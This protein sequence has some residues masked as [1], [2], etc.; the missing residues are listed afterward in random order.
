MSNRSSFP[1]TADGL[2][3]KIDT[4][5]F[6]KDTVLG[7]KTR[8]AADLVLKLGDPNQETDV[9]IDNLD[10]LRNSVLTG[11]DDLVLAGYAEACVSVLLKHLDTLGMC[12]TSLEE[13]VTSKLLLEVSSVGKLFSAESDQK[14]KLAQHK[15]QI[16]LRIEVHWL[17]ENEAKQEQYKASMLTHLK[18]IS[19]HG[20]N[21]V[22]TEFL[23]N[24]LSEC[25]IDRQPELLS[26]LYDKL[27]QEQP[28]QPAM[29]F[30]QAGLSANFGSVIPGAH[31]AMASPLVLAKPASNKSNV[32]SRSFSSRPSSSDTLSTRQI[33]IGAGKTEKNLKVVTSPS[34]D[35]SCTRRDS[36][37][38][39]EPATKGS[40]MLFPHLMNKKRK[41]KDRL[42]GVNSELVE[43]I[44]LPAHSMTDS[45]HSVDARS[46]RIPPEPNI[47]SG[48]SSEPQADHSSP[49][50]MPDHS[51]LG[52][53][54]VSS[55][56]E[57]G[58]KS[59][60]RTEQESERMQDRI[61][62]LLRKTTLERLKDVDE[63]VTVVGK[64]KKTKSDQLKDIKLAVWEKHYQKLSGSLVKNTALKTPG[65]REFFSLIDT[66]LSAGTKSNSFNLEDDYNFDESDS[67]ALKLLKM[68]ENESL[69]CA[70]ANLVS[71]DGKVVSLPLPVLSLAWPNLG[72][73]VSEV[74]H[75]SS[76]I[77]ICLPCQGQT[78][79][80]FKEMIFNGRTSDLTLT[81]ECLLLDFLGKVGL[82][83]TTVRHSRGEDQ[84]EE[85]VVIGEIYDSE[86]EEEDSKSNEGLGLVA[87][88]WKPR[89]VQPQLASRKLCSPM[90]F[91]DCHQVVKTWNENDVKMAKDTFGGSSAC[92]TKSKMLIHLQHQ[93]KIGAETVSFVLLGHSFCVGFLN[94]LTGCS[95]YL[96]KTV[97]KDY[98]RGV[99][100][101]ENG[102]SGII[103]NISLATMGFIAWFKNFLSIYGQN[104][105]DS[106]VLFKKNYFCIM[107]SLV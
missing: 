92:S 27:N 65:R 106:Q 34:M 77:S 75:C 62:G 15:V 78:L 1:E 97:L 45:K 49:G 17:L 103:K 48:H 33:N 19:F 20:G 104:A 96:L 73:I 22:M 32:I 37:D 18:Q 31:G 61:S 9:L 8:A 53:V 5:T 38:I 21:N 94:H 58:K 102:N 99:R 50:Y 70:S 81:D 10:A 93:R 63:N 13:V 83:W 6:L 69:V 107:Y 105:P 14:L 12:K 46:D 100:Q 35:Q 24:V 25:Y 7:S 47:S 26:F 60:T 72:L 91:N 36:T 11:T 76:D 79:L 52:K 68:F 43:D 84:D 95:V 29:L 101:F 80:H 4:A 51:S 42:G 87:H 30:S 56:N 82:E 89:G 39:M 57:P 59:T 55:P 90:C 85:T 88:F 3:D 44:Q 67:Y 86:E 64:V 54:Q 40:L 41:I 66:Q 28:C 16:L 98:R 23:S 71:E 74:L 2:A